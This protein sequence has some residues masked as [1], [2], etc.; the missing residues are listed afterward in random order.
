M[1]ISI[2]KTAVATVLVAGIAVALALQAHEG[3]G[4]LDD[5]AIAEGSTP[6]PMSMENMQGM[7]KMEGMQGGMGEM[8]AACTKM[9]EAHATGHQKTSEEDKLEGK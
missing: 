4:T 1:N 2:K 5:G 3:P 7:M 8:M 9:M 6:M